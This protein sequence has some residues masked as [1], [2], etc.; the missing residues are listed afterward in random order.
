M[1]V[2]GVPPYDDT[3]TVL[4]EVPCVPLKLQLALRLVELYLGTCRPVIIRS[5]CAEKAFESNNPRKPV[6]ALWHSSLVYTL[7]HFRIYPGTIMTS[8]SRDGAWIAAAVSQWGQYPVRGS[9][10]K[11]GL[12]AVRQM[13]GLMRKYKLP[14]GIVADG[15]KGPVNTAQIG[16]VILARDTGSPIIPTGFAASRAVYFNSWDRMV[17][18]LPFSRV[19]IVYEEMIN[20]PPDT[21]GQRVEYFRKKLEDMLNSA[22][23]EA[24]RRM[25]FI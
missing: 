23:A 11:G 4:P 25:G 8:A 21:R 9:K 12:R 13:A 1:K 17:L 3:A 20:V 6:I 5:R 10:L 18:P 19:C 15:S 24:G 22:T 16:A 14:A 2:R 7:Y